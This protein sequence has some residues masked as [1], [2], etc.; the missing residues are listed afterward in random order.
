T[1]QIVKAVGPEN[2]AAVI[3][4]T[5]FGAGSFM[6]HERYLPGLLELGRKYGFLWIDDEVITGFGRLGEWFGYQLYDGIQP[7]LMA[8]GKGIN[9]C[10]L[11]V[12]GTIASR[13]IGEYFDRARWMIGAT[14]EAH[15]LAC[16]SI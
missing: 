12:G 14:H 10:A 15:P 13:E 2:V 5:M 9:S 11:P 6:P 4:E 1:E 3:T 16:A 8:V 7:D